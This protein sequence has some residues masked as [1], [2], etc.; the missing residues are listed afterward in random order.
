[1]QAQAYHVQKPY[2]LRS[3]V[4]WYLHQVH[5]EHH[6]RGV[7][8]WHHSRSVPLGCPV[9]L[10]ARA[11]VVLLGILYDVWRRSADAQSSA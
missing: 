6:I 10:A 5:A 1:M 2:S 9:C 3:V 4:V 11:L 8:L 7:G